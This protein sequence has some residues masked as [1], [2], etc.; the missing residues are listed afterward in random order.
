MKKKLCS[1]IFAG[2]IVASATMPIQ[3]AEIS[4]IN[5]VA[6]EMGDSVENFVDD[7]SAE[8]VVKGIQ[9]RGSIIDTATVEISNLGKGDIGIMVET[10]AHV[11]CSHIKQIAILERQ[12]DDGTWKEVS[13]YQYDAYK[14][15]FQQK[16]Y[17]A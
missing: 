8:A 6:V 1:L 17:Q 2:I 3:A 4:T 7:N 11:E 10:L 14:K 5:G 13:R 15:V 9:Q 12:E 16:I